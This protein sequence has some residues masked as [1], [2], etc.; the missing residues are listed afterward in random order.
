MVFSLTTQNKI[1]QTVQFSPSISIGKVQANTLNGEQVGVPQPQLGCIS[2]VPLVNTNNNLAAAVAAPTSASYISLT[3]GAGVTA[4]PGVYNV[5]TNT[6][7]TIY[8]FD[9]PRAVTITLGAGATPTIFTVWGFDEDN[10]FM[11]EQISAVASATTSGKKA[12]A[13]V[14]RVWA[15]GAT[16]TVVS[17]GTSGIIGLPYVLDN[18]NRIMGTGNYG[19]GNAFGAIG[20]LY[21]VADITNPATAITGDVRGTVNLTSLTIDSIKRFSVAWIMAALPFEVS[22]Q[23]YT[24]V[25][26]VPQYAA[27]YN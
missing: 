5:F 14:T 6:T 4:V 10:V 7:D 20:A 18:V 2:V 22:Q 17:I 13:G 9:I 1:Y 15:A 25:Y 26:G 3:A 8:F 21:T 12:F 24:T 19:T 23:T 11:T 16:V 27:P